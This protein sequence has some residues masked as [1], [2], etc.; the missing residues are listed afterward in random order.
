MIVGFGFLKKEKKKGDEMGDEIWVWGVFFSCERERERNRAGVTWEISMIHSNLLETD[1]ETRFDRLGKRKILS[2]CIVSPPP[3]SL[4]SPKQT[5][6]PP[7]S[8]STAPPLLLSHTFSPPTRSRT[9][10]CSRYRRNDRSPGSNTS[11]DPTLSCSD[12]NPSPHTHTA[13]SR[14]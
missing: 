12:S 6:Q 4:C 1:L 7:H 3:P 9:P 14:G 2:F 5:P 13:W 10:P 11:D 8:H